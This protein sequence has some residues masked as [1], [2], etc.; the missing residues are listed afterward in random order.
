MSNTSQ[1]AN[2]TAR[3]SKSEKVVS[4]LRRKTGASLSEL[5]KATGWQNHSMHGFMSGTLK[6]KHSF[7]VI[8]TKEE[9]KD[10]RYFIGEQS[11]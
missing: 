8:S 1:K 10:R 4:L 2:K 6:K 11:K 7:S 5:A 9:N 3:H